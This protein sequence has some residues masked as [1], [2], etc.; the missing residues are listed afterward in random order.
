MN[1]TSNCTAWISLNKRSDV[2]EVKVRFRGEI[3]FGLYDS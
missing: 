1:N 2:F 3:S